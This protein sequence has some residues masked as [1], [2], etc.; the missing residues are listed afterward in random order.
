MRKVGLGHTLGKAF[1]FQAVIIGVVAVLSVWAAAFVLEEV[2]IKEAL[3]DE[4]TYFWEQRDTDPAFP[5][6]DTR[7]LT[8]YLEND[9]G[10]PVPEAYRGFEAGFHKLGTGSG[11]SL[12][13]VSG[14]PGGRLYLLFDGENVGHLAFVFGLV[15]LAGVLVVLYLSAWISYRQS[16]RAVS[17]VIA[18]ARTVQTLD[19]EHPDKEAFQAP[20]FTQDADH[21]VA[22]LAEAL[23]RFAERISAFV[24]R[25]RNFT[26]DASHELRSPLTVIRIAADM[27]LSEQELSSPARTS[28][29]RIQRSAKD[30]EEL[31]EAFLL[32]ARESEQALSRDP[33]QV[34]AL[35]RDEMGRAV[36]L[37]GNE[38]IQVNL[39]EHAQLSVVASERVLSV[40]FGNLIRNALS[41]TD[42]GQVEIT[43][44]EDR[45]RIADSGIGMPEQEI[46]QVFKPFY[47]SGDSRRGGHGVGLTIV[48]NLSS[49]FGWTVDIDSRPQLGTTVT[50]RFPPVIIE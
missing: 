14:D 33:V 12:V 9:P 40:I 41:Y 16:R 30:M 45:V 17:P 6:P 22:T 1:L 34:N 29:L 38:R 28:V 32:L 26:R 11:F 2:L 23:A 46:Q 44:D 42:E 25:E 35:L 3:R 39:T 43:V 21:E 27:L 10:T 31:V 49:R 24:E 8:G 36:E 37:L 15:P 5:L 20:E 13:H 18:L 19:P 47:R 4:A 48:K 50:V 7:N